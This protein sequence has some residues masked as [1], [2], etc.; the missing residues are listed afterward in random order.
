MSIRVYIHYETDD[1]PHKKS[2][3]TVP[4]KWVAEKT[5][6]DVIG[7]FCDAYNKANP[8]YALEASSVHVVNNS[9]E[10]L[11]SD[12]II[13]TVMADHYDYFIHKGVHVKSSS[14]LKQDQVTEADDNRLRCRNYGCNQLYLEEENSD[15]ACRHHVAPPIFHDRVK[16][17][18]CCKERKAY[19]WEEVSDRLG[20]AYAVYMTA[21]CNFVAPIIINYTNLPCL[22]VYVWPMLL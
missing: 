20:T 22:C 4:K 10:K 5:V 7:L 15:S 2:K 16:G 6:V 1:A 3:L 19:D 13:G 8:E 12:D 9:G 18:S 17:W 14:L 11:Y 21:Q